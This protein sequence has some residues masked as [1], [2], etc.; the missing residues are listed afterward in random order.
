MG[1]LGLGLGVV[2]VEE[3]Q[4]TAHSSQ[5]GQ[6]LCWGI[7]MATDIVPVQSGVAGAQLAA[8]QRCLELCMHKAVVSAALPGCGFAVGKVGVGMSRHHAITRVAA[9]RP[10]VCV[11][12]QHLFFRGTAAV[13]SPF[14]GVLSCNHL[15]AQI[16]VSW[17]DAVPAKIACR[18]ASNCACSMSLCMPSAV[19]DRWHLSSAQQLR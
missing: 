3:G 19:C 1:G 4:G 15:L 18:M 14:C 13:R 11:H 2:C 6:G 12:A 9:S 16:R 17:F 7:C 8:M 10:A 5:G